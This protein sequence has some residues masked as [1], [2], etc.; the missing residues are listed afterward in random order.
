MRNTAGQ[1]A[2]AAVT[3]ALAGALADGT[4]RPMAFVMLGGAASRSS[5]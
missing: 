4:A 1:L 2:I 3:A 5:A